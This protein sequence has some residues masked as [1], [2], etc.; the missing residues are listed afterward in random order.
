VLNGAE[1]LSELAA[2]LVS[3]GLT[4]LDSVKKGLNG[5][6]EQPLAGPVSLPRSAS[7]EPPGAQA[8][9]AGA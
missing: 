1:G 2:G 5:D 6:G 9:E 8:D 4:I 7:N 3:Q